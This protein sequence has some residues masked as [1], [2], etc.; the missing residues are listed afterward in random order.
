MVLQFLSDSHIAAVLS[1][2]FLDNFLYIGTSL[3]SITHYLCETFTFICK[4]VINLIAEKSVTNRTDYTKIDDL[5]YY[6]PGGTSTKNLVHWVQVYDSK[7]VAEFDY[8]EDMNM[9]VYG[10]STPPVFDLS[11]F[12]NYKVKSWITRSDAD[13]FSAIRDT[14]AFVDLVMDKSYI[15]I[16]DLTNYN[17]LDYLWSFDAVN[18]LY[19]DV[20]A[21]LSAN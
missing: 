18:D 9:N 2:L 6:E 7:N 5:Y 15:T 11:Q 10:Q 16:K 20:I 19:K 13:P 1:D 12:N 4:T 21:F 3:S 8:G 17:H 14:T